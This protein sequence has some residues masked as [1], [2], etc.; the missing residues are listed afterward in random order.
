[1]KKRQK[2]L[3]LLLCC[4]LLLSNATQ[5]VSAQE[6][7]PDGTVITEGAPVEE[8]PPEELPAEET[9]V[10]NEERFAQEMAAGGS[11]TVSTSNQFEQALNNNS[12]TEIVVTNRITLCGEA[13]SED[14][15]ISPV[16]IRGNVTIKGNGSG[17]LTLRSPIQLTGDNVTFQNIEMNFISSGALGSV[18]HR[19]IFL[20]GHTLTLDNV[21]CYTKGSDGSLGGFGGDEAEL[22]PTVYAGGYRRTNVQP[23]GAGLTILNSN[24][25]TNIQGIYAGHDGGTD[26]KV[27]YT[28]T[29]EMS[30]D[31]RVAVRDGIFASANQSP[32]NITVTGENINSCRTKYFE[33]N[34]NTTFTFDNISVNRIPVNGGNIVLKNGTVFEP[35][36]KDKAVIDSIKVQAGT[37]L[38]LVSMLGT[39]IRGDFT[40]GGTLVLDKD[41][42]L[43]IQG[44]VSGN[45]TFKTWSGSLAG[46]GNLADGR[47]YIT[48]A[49]NQGGGTFQ[50]DSSYQNYSLE[51]KN[52]VWT[53]KNTLSADQREF[54]SFEVLSF[55]E[56]IDY[57]TVRKES[58]S[59]DMIEPSQIF[60]TE[61]K[62]VNGEVYVPED[63]GAYVLRAEDVDQTDKK[64]WATDIFIM[65]L[66]NWN[67]GVHPFEGKYY[68]SF[69]LDVDDSVSDKVKPGKYKVFFT[70][71]G[72]DNGTVGEIVDD[73][74][75]SAEFM[76]YQNTGVQ[77]T[78][79]KQEHVAAIPDQSY[80]GKEIKPAVQV[81]VGGINLT[82]GQDYI[83]KYEN[84]KNV[85]SDSSK[86][87]VI[88]EGIGT[89]SGK[90]E[91]PFQ[92]VKGETETKS[93][94]TVEK[95]AYAYGEVV[96]FHF[97]AEPKKETGKK[98][99]TRSAKADTVD[100]YFGDTLLGSADVVNGKATML[101]DT[102]Q[103]KIPVGTADITVDFG[104][105]AQ[106]KAAKFTEKDLLVL[107]KR[108]LEPRDIGSISLEDLVYDGKTKETKVTG[109]TWK[110]VSVQGLS[111]EGMAELA[112]VDAGSYATADITK[113]SFAGKGTEWYDITAL[114]GQISN[115]KVSPEAKIQKAQ[116]S[117]TVF[118]TLVVDQAG[119]QTVTFDKEIVPD[120][121]E[122][123]SAAEG[124]KSEY[125]TLIKEVKP[126]KNDVA[127]TVNDIGNKE[128]KGTIHV[129]LTFKN[130]ED[131]QL[132]IQVTKTSKQIVDPVIHIPNVEYDGSEY[133]AW[134]VEGYDKN[135]I[136]ATYF[137]LDEGKILQ[138]APKKAGNY[139]VTLILD[140]GTS[141]AEKTLKFT[142]E[143]KKTVLKAIDRKIKIGETAPNL[144]SPTEGVDYVFEEGGKPNQGDTI[145]VIKMAY[146][147]TPN[148][149][150]AGTYEIQIG[151]VGDVNE[152][153]SVETKGATLEVAAEEI[154]K[155]YRITV[156]G[157]LADRTTAKAGETVRITAEVPDGQQFV[158]WNSVSNGVVFE[159][160]EIAE[161]T[162]VMPANE[163][164]ITAEF[165]TVEKPNPE[166]PD[167]EQ[168][169][170]D[171]PNPE[172][173]DPDKPNP[174]QPDPD[175]P[176]PNDPNPDN[177][178]Q[179]KPGMPGSQDTNQGNGDHAD[180][181][182][183][184]KV[185]TDKK[186]ENVPQTGDSSN[187]GVI[188]AALV[189]S[190][191]VI[192]GVLIFRRRR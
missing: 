172:Q 81:T 12:V 97:I 59:N 41:D 157:G 113:L 48:C 3:S 151:I 116:S 95:N 28:G 152:N 25:K 94:L 27:P 96:R 164:E 187:V 52:G 64:D 111:F 68:I 69:G 120:G 180:N 16:M 17:I 108:K 61:T 32:V 58:L 162:F 91:A 46:I 149:T 31:S 185:T 179:G 2:I 15:S 109:I 154:P 117:G 124:S 63:F 174:E 128:E 155:E 43:T 35:V 101:Y 87:K 181:K 14:Y 55:P 147:S 18:P 118:K 22:L 30:I 23:N 115:V 71:A 53:A 153:Y 175:K 5:F 139:S 82:E 133:D 140:D 142:I 106:L 145:G 121:F 144:D 184:D 40:G 191:A 19:E 76:I 146:A 78:E 20:A 127:F 9:A 107:N 169:D 141:Y 189:V 137:D 134:S 165:K 178:T 70:K 173:P 74:I 161:T 125:G 11:V 13:E 119:Q 176:N 90:V 188:G 170:P 112:S 136:R 159:N 1:M 102:T 171:K 62:D 77:G 26:N 37:I 57:E 65:E 138:S 168:P 36:A 104:G 29:I 160:A 158:R 83:L 126:T 148:T 130:H 135:Q 163:V 84:N 21:S 34:A 85:T 7:Q 67:G 131:V 33:G 98:R 4:G 150:Q 110:D 100:F 38:N 186:A 51:E 143:K 190:L 156:N 88:V 192:V 92:I 93:A 47:A 49:S 129:V 24:D 44:K 72:H 99:L 80:T 75:G 167:P 50:L 166:Q 73:A 114:S 8:A 183:N 86:A 182:P 39:V 42:S 66:G 56:F 132:I 89:Y 122:V 79:I 54:G 123:K 10:G 60:V 6:T 177:S 103:Q 45:T 105:N